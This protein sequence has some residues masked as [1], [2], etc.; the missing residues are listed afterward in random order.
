MNISNPSKRPVPTGYSIILPPGWIGI[1]LRDHEAT[2]SAVRRIVEKA[3]GD[4][5][6]SFPRDKVT[7]YRLEIERRLR[8]GISQARKGEGLDLYLP[9]YEQGR[10][11]IGASFVVAETAGPQGSHADAES[12]LALMVDDSVESYCEPVEIA[13]STAVRRDSLVGGKGKQDAEAASRRVDY[14]IPVPQNANRW[15]VVSFST[16]GAGDPED[17][18]AEAT[19]EL[20]DAIMTTFRWRAA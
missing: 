17:E 16:V 18:I 4:L 14:V 5:P 1:P 6:T 19:T 10:V 3:C 11:P 15:V 20:F 8:R 9:V 13:E 2:D 12:I 7:P